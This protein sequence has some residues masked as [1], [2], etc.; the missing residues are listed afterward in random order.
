MITISLVFGSIL[1]VFAAYTLLAPLLTN[2]GQF[3][4]G[5]QLTCPDRNSRA[6][7]DVNSVTAAIAKAYGVRRVFVRKCSL[8]KPGDVCDEGCLR[9]LTI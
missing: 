4:N 5:F 3:G 9:N 7:V 1:I 8:L 6:Q 2:Y